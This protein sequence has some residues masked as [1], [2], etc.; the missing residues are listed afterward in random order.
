MAIIYSETVNMPVIEDAGTPEEEA[1]I[2]KALV[3]ISQ[4]GTY[5]PFLTISFRYNDTRYNHYVLDKD[6]SYYQTDA[7]RDF[8][9]LAKRYRGKEITEYEIDKI[10][11]AVDRLKEE[12]NNG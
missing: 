4:V 12:Y 7:Q 9:R 2:L 8:V 11:E 6:D 10:K 5:K 3:T 1:R